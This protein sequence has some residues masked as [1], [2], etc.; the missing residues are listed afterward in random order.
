MTQSGK[1]I[2]YSVIEG[3]PAEKA[4]LK[5]N[6]I[7]LYVDGKSVNGLDISKVAELVRGPENTVVTLK[8]KRGNYLLTKKIV[9]KKIEIKSVETSVKNNNIGYIKIKSFIGSNTASEVVSGL[10]TVKDTK[11]LIIDLRGNTG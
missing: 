6:D 8:I 5:A 3:T 7:I 2:I 1:P 4:G 10:K 9:R 11:G